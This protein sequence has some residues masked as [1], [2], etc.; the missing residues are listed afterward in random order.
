MLKWGGFSCCSRGVWGLG[1][2]GSPTPI[3]ENPAE[4]NMENDIGFRV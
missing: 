2:L 4:E 3:M 1:V